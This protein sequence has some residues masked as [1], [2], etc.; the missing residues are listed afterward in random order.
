[1]DGF[2]ATFFFFSEEIRHYIPLLDLFQKSMVSIYLCFGMN[3]LFLAFLYCSKILVNGYSTYS[4]GHREA[5]HPSVPSSI[6]P[7]V[8]SSIRPVMVCLLR[9]GRERM[10]Y[11]LL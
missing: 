4:K 1:M 2:F 8:R 6:R 3:N 10:E 7:S 11:R 9:W 5:F